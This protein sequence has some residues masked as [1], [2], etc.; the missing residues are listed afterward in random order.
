[1]ASKSCRQMHWNHPRP[2]PVE[3]GSLADHTIYLGG[4]GLGGGGGLQ[5]VADTGSERWVLGTNTR[6][7][8][9]F[10]GHTFREEADLAAEV[11]CRQSRKA[12][13]QLEKSRLRCRTCIW[14]SATLCD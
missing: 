2:Y 5:A 6:T 7:T 11:D 3:A 12:F 14:L 10:R 1:M 8:R 4:S 9:N 13:K